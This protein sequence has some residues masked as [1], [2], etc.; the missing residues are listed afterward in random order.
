MLARSQTL[1][2][3]VLISSASQNLWEGG[4]VSL[5]H[6]PHEARLSPV[7]TLPGWRTC[8]LSPIRSHRL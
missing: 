2:F 3:T 1:Y 6:F 5:A 7:F 8:R 4:S